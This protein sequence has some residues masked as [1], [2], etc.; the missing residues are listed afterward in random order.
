MVKKMKI[1]FALGIIATSLTITSAQAQVRSDYIETTRIRGK[2]FIILMRRKFNRKKVPLSK[3]Y[4]TIKS[5]V[6]AT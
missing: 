4:G 3:W 5:V 1:F 2:K 6:A